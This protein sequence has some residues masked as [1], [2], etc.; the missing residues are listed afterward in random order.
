MLNAPPIP[1]SSP[2]PIPFTP[3]GYWWRTL[4]CLADIIPLLFLGWALAGLMAGPDELA[5][6]QDT[7]AWMHRFINQ[8]VKLFSAGGSS[9]ENQALMDMLLKPDPKALEAMSVWVNFQGMVTFF[10]L[11]LTLT[12][13]EWQMKGQTIGKMIFNLRTIDI[14]TRQPPVFFG[15]LLRSA[16]KASF[17]ALPNPIFMVIGILNF[18]VP[19]FRRD[20][21]AWHDLWT[22]SQVVESRKS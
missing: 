7:D 20:R 13:Q 14:G 9:R 5:A 19:L 11:M 12:F 6:R 18:H 16:W 15:C 17:F 1:P 2:P 10:T 22:R 8:Y 21:R 4:A 3:A